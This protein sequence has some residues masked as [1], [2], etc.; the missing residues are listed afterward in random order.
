MKIVINKCYGGFSLSP[1]AVARLCELRGRPCYFFKDVISDG[2]YIPFA[3]GVVADTA[4]WTA[5][6]VPNPN[7]YEWSKLTQEERQ[8]ANNW[9]SQ[10]YITAHPED[11]TDKLL[12]QVV[13]ELGIEANGSYAM[14]EVIEIPDGVDWEIDEYD[15]MESIHEKHRSWY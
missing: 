9:Y 12:V 1:K 4:F 5:F 13:E 7:V 6:D 14:L 3:P 15:G 2:K 11:R 8:S 10:H